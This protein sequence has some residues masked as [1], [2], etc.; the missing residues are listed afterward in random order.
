MNKNI[1][2]RGGP[3]PQSDVHTKLLMCNET[4]GEE[5]WNKPRPMNA[6][7]SQEKCRFS[8]RGVLLCQGL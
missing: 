7:N 5:Q 6:H 3:G 8:C 4:K 2:K 1:E